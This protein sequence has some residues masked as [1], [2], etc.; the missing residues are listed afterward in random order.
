MLKHRH[1]NKSAWIYSLLL[2]PIS[3]PSAQCT[4]WTSGAS[5][6][7]CKGRSQSRVTR[8]SW[9]TTSIKLNLFA[10]GHLSVKL[11]RLLADEEDVPFGEQERKCKKGHGDFCIVLPKY[12]LRGIGR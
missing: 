2:S 3:P 11:L 10:A 8:A 9:P 6:S 4:F 12:M 1:E 5:S 7:A